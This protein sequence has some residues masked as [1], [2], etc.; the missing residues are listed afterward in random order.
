MTFPLLLIVLVGANELQAPTT[1]ALKD[2]AR[3]FLGADAEVRV[4]RYASPPADEELSS[5]RQHADAVAQLSWADEA[6]RHALVRCYL[7]SS[8]RFVSREI[9][10][11]GRDEMTERGKTLGFAI[12]SML[13]K[14]VG[15]EPAS[16]SAR[17][18]FPEPRPPRAARPVVASERVI[19]RPVRAAAE[20]AVSHGAIDVTALGASGV[21]GSGGGVGAG[22]AARWF[23]RHPMSLR[24]AGGIRYGRVE[25]A[26]ANGTAFLGGLGLAFEFT[27]PDSRFAFGGRADALLTALT[28]TRARAADAV[29][30]TQTRVQPAAD[31]LLE[32]AWYLWDSG[33]VLFAAGGEF[34]LGHTDV[35]V[36][37]KDVIDIA[38]FRLVAELGA[39][40]RF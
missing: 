9:V 23:F 12:A 31:L 29:P 22:L 8:H 34:G 10:F 17:E 7:E 4:E 28:L 24:L 20:G 6:R 39:R 21:A 27:R 16:D 18:A 13:A 37:N 3:D 36:Q 32:G 30:E 35:V 5:N 40:A 11:D 25:P 38:A 1:V 15:N 33:A 19:D 14:P 26:Q 2:A